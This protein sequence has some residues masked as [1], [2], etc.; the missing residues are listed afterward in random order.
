[1]IRAT[2]WSAAMVAILSIIIIAGIEGVAHASPVH[3]HPVATQAQHS[4][5]CAADVYDW[6]EGGPYDYMFGTNW[7]S[8]PANCWQQAALRCHNRNGVEHWFHGG[9]VTPQGKESGVNC[10]VNYPEPDQGNINWQQW[11]VANSYY[12][13]CVWSCPAHKA[14]LTAAVTRR[15][16]MKAVNLSVYCNSTYMVKL[17]VEDNLDIYSNGSGKDM[18]WEPALGDY[19]F[20]CTGDHVML[21]TAGKHQCLKA[22]TTSLLVAW[23]Q[24]C[25][26]GDKLEMWRLF[27][28]PEMGADKFFLRSDALDPDYLGDWGPFPTRGNHKVHESPIQANFATGLELQS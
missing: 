20:L 27:Y 19:L 26:A 10:D 3:S 7:D 5:P 24:R 2:L 28:Q 9:M 16:V 1:M 15:P 18:T 6:H 8:N 14:H 23:P 21:E 11:P 13:T 4:N 12:Y 25:Y 17:W 22:T